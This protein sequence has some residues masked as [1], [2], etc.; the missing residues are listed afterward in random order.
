MMGHGSIAYALHLGNFNKK[1][2]HYSTS[3]NLITQGDDEGGGGGLVL[4]LCGLRSIAAHRDH[5]VRLPVRLSVCLSVCPSVRLP[6][7]LGSQV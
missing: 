7:F 4:L 1:C 2:I 3:S 5:F 6:H